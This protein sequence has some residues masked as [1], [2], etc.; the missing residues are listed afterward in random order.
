[1]IGASWPCGVGGQ[2]V[3][4]RVLRDEHPPAGRQPVAA[5]REVE[6]AHRDWLAG[7]RAERGQVGLQ[8]QLTERAEPRQRRGGQHHARVRRLAAR[9]QQVGRDGQAAEL[10]EQGLVQCLSSVGNV[11][12]LAV[13][14]KKAI[15][16]IH[17]VFAGTHRS[18]DVAP[19]DS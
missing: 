2:R 10:H 4:R 8:A 17:G 15:A 6:V 7:E 16:P 3:H 18:G 1:L 9:P 12:A 19:G 14:D 11:S 5:V 13:Q